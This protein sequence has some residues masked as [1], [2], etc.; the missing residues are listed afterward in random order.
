MRPSK[1]R[2]LSVCVCA[3]RQG[4]GAC[5][6]ISESVLHHIFYSKSLISC[7]KA[8]FRVPFL[9]FLAITT[10]SCVQTSLSLSCFPGLPTEMVVQNVHIFI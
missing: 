6:C 3:V 7:K 9:D 10:Q 4:M 1:T 2:K 8:N 5:L